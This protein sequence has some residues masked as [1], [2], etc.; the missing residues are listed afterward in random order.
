LLAR[1][2]FVWTVLNVRSP[3]TGSAASSRPFQRRCEGR[4]DD[5]TEVVE[6]ERVVEN[7]HFAQ[8]LELAET[9]GRSPDPIGG[10]NFVTNRLTKA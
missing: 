7:E 1:L 2:P 8:Q 6:A 9:S 5:R 4:L 3:T 10:A